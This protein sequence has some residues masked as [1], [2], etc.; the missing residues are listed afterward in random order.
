MLYLIY[1]KLKKM[2]FLYLY[3]MKS[4]K[5]YF[6]KR[7]EMFSIEYIFFGFFFFL[8]FLSFKFIGNQ[9]YLQKLL[10]IIYF[11]QISFIF[12]LFFL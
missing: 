6:K 10:K 12:L 2:V 11:L 4:T 3:A 1:E 9:T 5:K 8:F 7:E